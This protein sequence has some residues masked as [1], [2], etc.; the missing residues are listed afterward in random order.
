VIYD[1]KKINKIMIGRPSTTDLFDRAP[2]FLD[3]LR[4]GGVDKIFVCGGFK[5]AFNK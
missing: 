2:D 3:T 4:T 1:E 5:G